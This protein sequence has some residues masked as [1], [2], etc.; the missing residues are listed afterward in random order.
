MSQILVRFLVGGAI[1][2]RFMLRALEAGYR[3]I[4]TLCAGGL[5]LVPHYRGVDT[6]PVLTLH[7]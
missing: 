3:S 7:S 2:S 6:L 4:P 5:D 1:V